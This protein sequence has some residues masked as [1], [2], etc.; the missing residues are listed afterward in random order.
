MKRIMLGLAA[1]VVAAAALPQSAEAYWRG[2]AWRG[3]YR[4]GYV[5]INRGWVRPAYGYYGYRAAYAYR[6][7]GWNRFYAGYNRVWGRPWYP[8]YYGYR[9]A[10]PYGWYG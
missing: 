2:A 1:L 6:P 7:Y 8:G 9:A 3:A 10:A 4:P 5:G